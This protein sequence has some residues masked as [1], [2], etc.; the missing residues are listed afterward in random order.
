MLTHKFVLTNKNKLTHDVYELIFKWDGFIEVLAWQ[1][2]TFI[3]PKSWKRAYSVSY[4]NWKDHE[5]IIKRVE[6]W[7]GGSK[8]ICDLEIWD[9]IDVLW[10]LGKFI[11]NNSK[12]NKLFLW[13]GT[14]L[15]PLYFMINKCFENK[16]QNKL[17]LILWV[18]HKEDVFYEDKL[19]NFKQKYKN[20]DYLICLSRDEKYGTKKWYISDCLNK[21]SISNFEEF[22]ICWWPKVVWDIRYILEDFDVPKNQIYFEQY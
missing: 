5:F 16:I 7:K 11:L 22:Y 2:F 12:K 17:F 3:L 18:R 6:D 8:E 14:W 1:F 21:N 19:I 20:F 9:S 15:V 10:P 13:T 4:S